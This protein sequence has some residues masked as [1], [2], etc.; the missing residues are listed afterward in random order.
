[1]EYLR[2]YNYTM[3]KDMVQ[4]Q[5]RTDCNDPAFSCLCYFGLESPVPVVQGDVNLVSQHCCCCFASRLESISTI[6]AAAPAAALAQDGAVT[7]NDLVLLVQ[8][9]VGLSTLSPEQATRA[10]VTQE[11]NIDIQVSSPRLF[12]GGFSFF[13]SFFLSFLKAKKQPCPPPPS[14]TRLR[15]PNSSCSTRLYH[16]PLRCILCIF[17]HLVTPISSPSL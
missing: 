8:S 16:R 6:K 13:L 17:P 3:P 7:V 10:D 15:S 14:R 5:V 1:M 11:G 12:F 2:F 9:L 4:A